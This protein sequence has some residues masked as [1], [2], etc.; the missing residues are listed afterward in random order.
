MDRSLGADDED[1]EQED[2]CR[3]VILKGDEAVERALKR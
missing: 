2:R 1:D 3:C